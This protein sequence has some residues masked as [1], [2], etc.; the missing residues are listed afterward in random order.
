MC[1][2]ELEYS[3]FRQASGSKSNERGI[4]SRNLGF[5]HWCY[6]QRP[7]SSL[8]DLA[9]IRGLIHSLGLSLIYWLRL[10]KDARRFIFVCRSSQFQSQV[11]DFIGIF[12]PPMQTFFLAGGLYDELVS[13]SGFDDFSWTWTREVLEC[14][15]RVAFYSRR[16][17]RWRVTLLL[18]FL[19][20]DRSNV[21]PPV[22]VTM[23]FVTINAENIVISCY[24]SMLQNVRYSF[25][26]LQCLQIGGW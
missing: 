6:L 15:T 2:E 18:C 20:K 19:V 17:Q 21:P 1:L 22:S 23:S 24:V 11:M 5:Y 16:C 14:A 8:Y 26:F 3:C 13:T 25:A 10:T 12:L 9:A 7:F 4:A